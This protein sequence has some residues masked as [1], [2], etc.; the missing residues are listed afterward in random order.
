M[1][2]E[3]LKTFGKQK[4][5][6]II[7]VSENLAFPLIKKGILKESKKRAKQESKKITENNIKT[8]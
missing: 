1:K 8:K 6:D 4:K 2:V 5:G 7:E 3:V